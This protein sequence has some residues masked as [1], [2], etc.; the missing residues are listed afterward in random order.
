MPQLE[1][2]ISLYEQD[3]LLWS[4][5]TA[6]KLRARDFDNLDLENLIEEIEALGISQKKELMSRLIL[7]PR[8]KCSIA[9]SGSTVSLI[10][11]V[12]SHA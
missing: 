5:E 10:L 7:V 3:I 1:N 8:K 11:K 12:I 2:S 4:E 6:A 9:T